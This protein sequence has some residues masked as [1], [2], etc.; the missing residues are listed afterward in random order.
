EAREDVDNFLA[1]EKR[2]RLVGQET[3]Q[4]DET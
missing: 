4:K 1:I 2:P 3:V